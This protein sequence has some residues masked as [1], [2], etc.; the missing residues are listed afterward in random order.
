MTRHRPVRCPCSKEKGMIAVSV[1]ARKRSESKLE[2]YAHAIRLR[3]SITFL[4]LRDIGVK[5]K[6][7]NLQI[8]TKPMDQA[9]AEAFRAIA[10]KY[11]M[12]SFVAEYP[13]W[14]IDKLRTSLWDITRDMLLN[15]TRA[16]SIWPTNISEAYARRN[17]INSAIADCESMMKELELAIDVLPI[18]AEKYMRYVDEI[19]KEIELLKDRRKKDNKKIREIRE[20]TK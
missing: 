17:Y 12:A 20:S 16:Y 2:F 11:G 5:S 19:E 14:I 13:D 6:V 3:K 7:R 9:D 4:L 18:D 8:T 15:I 10:V 1:L